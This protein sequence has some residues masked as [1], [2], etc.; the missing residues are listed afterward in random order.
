[1]LISDWISDVCSSVLLHPSEG[2]G[3]LP[4]AVSQLHGLPADVFDPHLIG[5][6]VV[7]VGRRRLVLQVEGLHGH[8]DVMCQRLVHV[9]LQWR[10]RR[11][12]KHIRSEE[13]TSELQSIMRI[14]YAVF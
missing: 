1:M 12:R 2:I 10:S 6:D 8:L 4:I 5:P 11:C 9:A 3:D 13:N 14:S 7:I